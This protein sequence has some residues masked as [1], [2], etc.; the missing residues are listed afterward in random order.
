MLIKALNF[1][2][3]FSVFI[4]CLLLLRTKYSCRTTKLNMVKR[5][6]MIEELVNQNYSYLTENDL[7]IWNYIVKNK[8]KVAYMSIN[9]VALSCNVSRTTIMR[10]CQKLGFNGFSE[11]KYAVK[12]ELESSKINISKTDNT[13]VENYMNTLNQLEQK[14]FDSICKMLS[15]AKRIFIY[16]SGDIQNLASKY[17][18]LLFLHRGLLIYDLDALYV[19]QEFYNL[20]TEDDVVILITLSGDS[21]P[22][23]QIAK[24]LKNRNIK[25][26]A[27]SKLKDSTI[28]KLST[29]RIYI[30]NS[31]ILTYNQS[32]LFESTSI[33]FFVVEILL[34]KYNQWLINNPLEF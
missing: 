13:L 30:F 14:D 12:K 15:E 24:K 27:I 11:F 10:F 22:I 21:V 5:C 31:Q 2:M 26:I 18:K 23:E 33:L 29:E 16:G 8:Q 28:A 19:N 32:N 1:N 34:L 17:L 9:E 3:V 6:R 7:F 20:I 25:S 4:S